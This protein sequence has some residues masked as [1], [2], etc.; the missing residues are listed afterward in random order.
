[1]SEVSLKR[2]LPRRFSRMRFTLAICSNLVP[3]SSLVPQF[4]NVL[5]FGDPISCFGKCRELPFQRGHESLHQNLLLSTTDR[6]L[7]LHRPLANCTD[8]PDQVTD[9]SPPRGPTDW[10]AV[11]ARTRRLIPREVVSC[12]ST[13]PQETAE[14]GLIFG[15]RLTFG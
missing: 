10:S 11:Y 4:D 5:E 8:H 13:E 14:K 3:Q 6:P 7:A 12:A 2:K 9:S 15:E 1:M